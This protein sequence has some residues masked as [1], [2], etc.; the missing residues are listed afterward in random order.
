[1]DEVINAFSFFLSVLRKQTFRDRAELLKLQLNF[2]PH[3]DGDLVRND[4]GTNLICSLP[5]PLISYLLAPLPSSPVTQHPFFP[6]SV[7]LHPLLL[8]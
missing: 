3:L 4:S 6:L 2:A 1:M 8:L 5:S 7:H